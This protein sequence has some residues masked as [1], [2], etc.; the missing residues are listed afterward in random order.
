MKNITL[1]GETSDRITAL[2]LK[3]HRKMLNSQIR[4]KNT[5]PEDRENYRELVAAMDLLLTR[6]FPVL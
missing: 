6:Y 5:H 2:T 1:D 4:A 3:E